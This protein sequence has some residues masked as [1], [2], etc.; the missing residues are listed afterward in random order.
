MSTCLMFIALGLLAPAPELQPLGAD[1][2]IGAVCELQHALGSFA[3]NLANLEAETVNDMKLFAVA[4][5]RRVQGMLV[6][7]RGVEGEFARVPGTALRKDLNE[8]CAEMRTLLEKALQEL[9]GLEDKPNAIDVSCA[10]GRSL[11]AV[12]TFKKFHRA[13]SAFKPSVGEIITNP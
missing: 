11:L 3:T 7:L 4:Q 5:R 2:T 10:L 1:D 6:L 13:Q 12:T 8:G 9:K